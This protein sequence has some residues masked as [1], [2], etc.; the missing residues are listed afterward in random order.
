MTKMPLSVSDGWFHLLPTSHHFGLTITITITT[1]TSSNHHLQALPLFG[2]LGDAGPGPAVITTFKHTGAANERAN[3]TVPRTL[4]SLRKRLSWRGGNA[5]ERIRI[6]QKRG[7]K[8]ASLA[9]KL[10]GKNDI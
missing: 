5:R 9:L 3:G 7:E 2:T 8:N 6:S 10:I 1:T 4:G